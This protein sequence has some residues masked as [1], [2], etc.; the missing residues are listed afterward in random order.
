MSLEIITKQGLPVIIMSWKAGYSLTL[1]LSTT[2]ASR[3]KRFGVIVRKTALQQQY[4]GN[5]QIWKS[6]QGRQ[7]E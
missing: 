5:L 7:Q 3:M 6:S 1:V 2:I 4:R